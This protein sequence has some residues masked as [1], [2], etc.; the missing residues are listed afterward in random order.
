MV[1]VTVQVSASSRQRRSLSAIASSEDRC[2]LAI[3]ATVTEV[4]DPR[5]LP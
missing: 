4:H 2:G 5:E 1:A 3:T